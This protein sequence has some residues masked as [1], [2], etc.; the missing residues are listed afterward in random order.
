MNETES[1]LPVFCRSGAVLWSLLPSSIHDM[2]L[3]NG[4]L[5]IATDDGLYE[6][7]SDGVPV[8]REP[9]YE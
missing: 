5:W 6:V 8:K 3:I 9:S 1:I 4:S 2:R 7:D